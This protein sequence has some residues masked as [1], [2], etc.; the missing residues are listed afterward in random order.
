MKTTI[1][2]FKIEGVE[3]PT[4]KQ[5]KGEAFEKAINGIDEKVAAKR[6]VM[7]NS[8]EIRNRLKAEL[9]E[10]GNALLMEDGE[11]EQTEL[12]TRRSE[13]GTTLNN[14]MDYSEFSINDYARKLMDDPGFKKIRTDAINEVNELMPGIK[15]YE[16]ALK[17]NVETMKGTLQSFTMQSGRSS[18]FVLR[19]LIHKCDNYEAAK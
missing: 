2:L 17:K 18:G 19:R 10:I 12:I 16:S 11:A 5:P 14:T 7:G 4:F 1:K 9:S 15:A 3:T 6:K 8:N 13:I